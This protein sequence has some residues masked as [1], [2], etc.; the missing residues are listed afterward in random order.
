VINADQAYATYDLRRI[1]L[2]ARRGDPLLFYLTHEVGPLVFYANDLDP[3]IR[4]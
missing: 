2:P 1:S 3:M 4:W